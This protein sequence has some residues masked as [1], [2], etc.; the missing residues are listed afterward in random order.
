MSET[1]FEELLKEYKKQSE[2]NTDE[3]KRIASESSWLCE[4]FQNLD[5]KEKQFILKECI[6]DFKNKSRKFSFAN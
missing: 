2:K 3:D 4:A 1:T 6:N 5:A